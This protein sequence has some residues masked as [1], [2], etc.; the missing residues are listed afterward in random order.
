MNRKL[1]IK[2]DAQNLDVH[3]EHRLDQNTIAVSQ[4]S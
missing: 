1:E 2:V 4:V 3:Y